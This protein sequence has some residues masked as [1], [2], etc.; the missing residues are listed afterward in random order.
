MAASMWSVGWR[1][2]QRGPQATR[3]REATSYGWPFVCYTPQTAVL[4]EEHPR[5][6][7]SEM[8]GTARI[9]A[10]VQGS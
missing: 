5:I 9:P 8:E 6:P 7:C 3:V 2:F 10:L 4:D 1:P